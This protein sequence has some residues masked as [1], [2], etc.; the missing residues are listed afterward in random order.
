[1]L[2]V[3]KSEFVRHLSLDARMWLESQDS[4]ES[5]RRTHSSRRHNFT[6]LQRNVRLYFKFGT[7]Q[8]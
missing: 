2:E 3:G 1:M 6:L 8:D 7:H 5:K 4:Q